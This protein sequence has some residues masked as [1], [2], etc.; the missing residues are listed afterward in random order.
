MH[1]DRRR[2]ASLPVIERIAYRKE[3]WRRGIRCREGLV[4]LCG[5]KLHDPILH[6]EDGVATSDLPFAVRSNARKGIAHF[7]GAE[8]AAGRTEHGR[9]IVLDGTLMCSLA[10]LGTRDLGRL[11]R[12]VK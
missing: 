8:N 3:I 1:A 2:C 9:S 6:G 11:P 4:S 5:R 7:D 12:Q 10:Q